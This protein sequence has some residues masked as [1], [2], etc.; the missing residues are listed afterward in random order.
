M[1]SKHDQE[2]DHSRPALVLLYGNTI[3]KHR[4]LDRDVI[5]VG[6]ARGCDLGLD[7][8]DISSIHCVITQ[9]P[10][11]YSVRDCQ[12]RAGTKLNGNVVK[13]SPLRDGDLLQIGPFSFRAHLPT[14]ALSKPL[15]SEKAKLEHLRHSRRKLAHI[16]LRQRKILRLHSAVDLGSCDKSS[17]GQQLSKQ[18]AALKDRVKDYDQRVR[19]LEDAERELI[20]DR[21]TLNNEMAAFRSHAKQVEDDLAKRR[22]DADAEAQKKSQELCQ[23]HQQKQ[24]DLEAL[25]SQLQFREQ[26]LQVRA[27]PLEAQQKQAHCLQEEL[28]RKQQNLKQQL[29]A[30]ERQQK[31]FSMVRDQW[32]QDQTSIIMRVGQQKSALAQAEETLRQQRQDLDDLLAALQDGQALEEHRENQDMQELRRENQELQRLLSEKPDQSLAAQDEQLRLECEIEDLQKKLAESERLRAQVQA[33]GPAGESEEIAALR[34]QL[35]EKTELAERAA[36]YA[37]RDIDSYEAELNQFRRQLEGDRQKLNREIEQLRA[38]N[39]ELDEATRE[40]ELEMSRERAEMARERQRLDRLREEVRLDV[41]R[42][43]RDAGLRDRL[44][45]V[46]NLREHINNR[47]P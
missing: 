34:Q 36:D 17:K 12:S 3:R 29:E 2:F 25:A 32:A 10:G 15:A 42:M 43:Q 41:E 38:K 40:L 11:G 24:R 22:H 31:E 46:Q 20:K 27:G 5:V 4:L 9:N 47:R 28:A 45:P 1:A 13:D 39:K 44:A 6:R 35:Q 37:P 18:L 21:D 14:G 7:A 33:P 19:D 26:Q 23:E 16:A 8:P 30:F